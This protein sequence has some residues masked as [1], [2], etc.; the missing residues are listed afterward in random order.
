MIKNMRK[1]QDYIP[2]NIPTKKSIYSLTVS[3]AI[4][5]NIA[6]EIMSIAP[7]QLTGAGDL[8]THLEFHQQKK[9]HFNIS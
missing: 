2:K 3:S 5:N 8:N 1:M 4:K 7:L 6:L 9:L